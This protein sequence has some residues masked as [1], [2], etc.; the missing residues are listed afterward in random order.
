[1]LREKIKEYSEYIN[2]WRNTITKR[3]VSR[4]DGKEGSK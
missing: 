4:P 3:N 2:T 1:L